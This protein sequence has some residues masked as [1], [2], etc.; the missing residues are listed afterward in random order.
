MRWGELAFADGPRTHRASDWQLMTRFSP[1]S[2]WVAMNQHPLE[3][4]LARDGRDQ[5][6]EECF[7]VVF[8]IWSII[9]SRTA[10]TALDFS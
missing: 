1:G 10:S 3:F 7:I 4:K 9:L 8:L 5:V 2:Q 6:K